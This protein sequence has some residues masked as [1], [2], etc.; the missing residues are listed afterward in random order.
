MSDF[1][2]DAHLEAATTD[3]QAFDPDAH[4]E[5]K[6]SKSGT[7]L[8][9]YSPTEGQSAFDLAMAGAGKSV[10]DMYHGAKQLYAKAADE[11]SP[12]PQTMSGLITGQDNSRSAEVQQE[13]DD[14][15]RLDKPLMQTGAGVGGYI[16]GSLASTVV[17]LGLAGKAAQGSGLARTGAALTSL[18]NPATLGAGV[19]SGAAQGALQPVETGGSRTLNTVSGGALGGAG[20][21]IARGAGSL[22]GMAIDK[23]SDSASSAVKALTDA[24]VP[25]DA[26]QRTGS[27]LWNRAKIMLGDNPITAG[28]QADF[29]DMQ[30]KSVN[31]AFLATTGENAAN[32]AT[33]DVMNRI[34]T[35][36]S[37]TYDDIS[38]RTNVPYD[39]IEHPLSNILDN[40]RLRLN[41]TQFG[42]VNRNIDDILNKASQNGGAI[43]GAQF[44]NIK[45]TLDKLSG[46]A[47]SDVGEVARDIRQTMNDGLLKSAS[48]AGNHADVA[49]LKQTN[50]QWRNMRTIEG[51]IDKEG[52]GDISPARLATIM[53]QKAN[54]SV[55]IYGQG[56]TSL[57][58]L[59]KASNEL[60]TNHTPNSGTVARLATQAALPLALGTAEGVKEGDWKGVAKGVA[61]GVAL[62]KI[63]QKLLNA[64]GARSATA[65]LGSLVKPASMPLYSGAAVQHAPLSTVLA[66]EQRYKTSDTS[67][68]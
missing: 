67:N 8:T 43:N 25:L 4:L 42:V 3:T 54:R 50:Q 61:A 5:A 7:T 29:A 38:S 26:A 28:A 13:I 17:P 68:P 6:T 21:L 2:P 23:L 55:S 11:I 15:A 52:S 19:V 41:D 51:A 33:P 35:R 14:A 37:N 1:D 64:Q 22:T 34:K 58:D 32:K 31:K 36:L 56:D 10:V 62:P 16:G 60:L 66:A 47:D 39:N 63:G 46:G 45:M 40:A 30:Q 53:N 20:N 59:A 24:G 27:M 9:K 65:A 18:A 12:R 57:S 49:A 44:K 48:D